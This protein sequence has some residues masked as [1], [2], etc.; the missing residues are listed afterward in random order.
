MN[1]MIECKTYRGIDYIRISELPTDQM[2]S[3]NNWINLDLIIKIQTEQR[4]LHDC[5]L[6]KDYEFW[7]N[8]IYTSQVS[9]E[10]VSNEKVVVSN[11]KSIGKL[12][13]D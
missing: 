13:F 9:A 4:L 2:E 5:L 11:T 8:N 10:E 3:I 12:V 1:S 6:Y 7:F